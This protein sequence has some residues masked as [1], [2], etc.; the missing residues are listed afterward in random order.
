MTAPIEISDRLA[1]RLDDELVVWLTTVRSDAT[2]QVSLVW[3]LWDGGE[4]LIYSEPGKAKLRNMSNNPVVSLNLNSIGDGGV[5]VF[6][7]EARL[8]PEDGDMSTNPRYVDKYRSLIEGELATSVEAFAT[9][10]RVAIRVA[11]RSLR[12]G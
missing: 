8:S 4:F 2:P 10:Y 6:T 1:Q 7:G 9:A 3:F 12:A 11:P 5:A